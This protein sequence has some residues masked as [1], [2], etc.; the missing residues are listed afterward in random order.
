MEG[1]TRKLHNQEAKQVPDEAEVSEKDHS[2]MEVEGVEV[3]EGEW[4]E[5]GNRLCFTFSMR[6]ANI[7]T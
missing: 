5:E 1:L 7:A 2:T 6:V 3:L 4:L